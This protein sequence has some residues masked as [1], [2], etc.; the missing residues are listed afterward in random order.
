MNKHNTNN[1]TNFGSKVDKD[2]AEEF[3][4]TLKLKGLKINFVLE[5]MMRNYLNKET[6]KHT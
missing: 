3:R 4:N 5:E 6:P 2:L 1:L